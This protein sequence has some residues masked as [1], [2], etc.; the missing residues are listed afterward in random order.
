MDQRI[1]C[2]C[3]DHFTYAVE[4]R[5]HPELV[6]QPV[7]IGGFP[8]ERKP[9][10]DCSAQAAN[11]GIAPGMPLRQARY[12]CPGAVFLP[13]D[14]GKYTRAF[15]EVL[16]ILDQ[17]SPIVE[18]EGPGRAFLDGAGLEGLF[19]PDAVLARLIATRVFSGTRLK[20]KIGIAGGKFIARMAA[21]AAEFRNPRIVA[22]GEEKHFLAPL[23]AHLVPVSEEVKRRFDLL[24]LRTLG[25][26]ASLPL[27]AMVNQFGEEGALAHRL[28][29]GKDGRRLVPRARPDILEHELSRANPIE[30]MDGLLAALNTALDRLIPS[31]RE[32]NGVCG[33]VRLCLKLDGGETWYDTFMLKTPTDS[34][35]EILT[36]LRHRLE[37]AHLTAG[38]SGIH[39][40][41]AQLGGEQGGQASLFKGERSR[42]EQKLESTVKRFRAR[43]GG[44]PLKRVVEADPDSRIPE[45]RSTLVDFEP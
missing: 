28:A 13:L 2:V 41:L 39:L 24:G 8:G 12:L 10:F 14:T 17:F 32:R 35:R 36:L 31:L 23:P 19:G 22:A 34:A 25:Q 43:Y 33:Q 29:H 20:P 7:V 9:V 42:R 4:A 21:D 6:S 15:N 37:N 44:N 16:D 3:I 45:R 5:E 26:I 1:I 40:G 30:T 18:I 11:A 27:E 38:V